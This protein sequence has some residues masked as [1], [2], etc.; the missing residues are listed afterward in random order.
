MVRR[1]YRWGGLP[2]DPNEARTGYA[3]VRR[4]HLHAEP[5]VQGRDALAMLPSEVQG[6]LPNVQRGLAHPL[7]EPTRPR[8]TTRRRDPTTHPQNG[9]SLNKPFFLGTYLSYIRA[10]TII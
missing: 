5:D 7:Q 4:V 8:K 3:A 6:L 2:D 1:N 10:R 9:G